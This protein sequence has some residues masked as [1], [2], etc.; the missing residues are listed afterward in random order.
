MIAFEHVSLEYLPGRFALQDVSFTLSAGSFT[1]LTG[2]SGAGKSSLLRL[3]ARLE[4]PSSGD[5]QVGNIHYSQL[6][7]RQEPALRQQ[8]GIVF[9][10]NQLLLDRSVFDNVAFPLIIGGY[11][12]SDIKTRVGAA[13]N[14]VGLADKALENPQVLS[15]GEQ[16]RIGIARAIVARPK[17]L[18]ADEPTGNLDPDISAEI[19]QL[20]MQFNAS[21]VTVLFATHDQSLLDTFRYPRLQLHQG[22]L[23][24]APQNADEAA[25]PRNRQNPGKG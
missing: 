16:Q 21:G 5:I 25:S 2:H 23:T 1:F 3:V 18:L 11:R 20:F 19:M 6:R 13:L 17:L 7:P 15:G 12:Y 24:S 8:M 9:Q 22:K 10:D 4:R 14:R